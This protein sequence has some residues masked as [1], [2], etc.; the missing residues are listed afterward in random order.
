MLVRVDH[1]EPSGL[2]ERG[3]SGIVCRKCIPH[4]WV[5]LLRTHRVEDWLWNGSSPKSCRF[6]CIL[7]R[8]LNATRDD[9]NRLEGTG[10]KVPVSFPVFWFSFFWNRNRSELAPFNRLSKGTE[11]KEPR[12]AVRNLGYRVRTAARYSRSRRL[13]CDQN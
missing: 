8:M 12:S 9:E 1:Y 2:C 3:F 5:A 10:T 4:C 6:N 13:G 7:S 11:P